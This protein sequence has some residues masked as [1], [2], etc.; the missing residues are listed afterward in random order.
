MVNFG[1]LIFL[2]SFIYFLLYFRLWAYLFLGIFLIS[3]LIFCFFNKVFNKL[4]LVYHVLMR[5][6][7]LFGNLIRKP[8]FALSRKLL[9]NFLKDVNL[10]WR[11]KEEMPWHLF[12]NKY[13]FLLMPLI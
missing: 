5:F 9:L 11:N 2:I 4:R 10:L 7:M 12:L 3:F 1:I 6:N 13:P 8:C